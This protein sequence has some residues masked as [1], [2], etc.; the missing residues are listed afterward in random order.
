MR[1]TKGFTLIELLVVI[2]IIALL[3]SILMPSLSKVRALA[4]RMKC[5]SNLSAIAK[6]FGMY[7]EDPKNDGRWP[8]IIG[9][10]WTSPSAPTGTNQEKAPPEPGED[11]DDRAITALPWMLIRERSVTPE[12]FVC[13]GDD[14]VEEYKTDKDFEKLW[15]FGE[16]DPR[17]NLSYVSYAYQAPV[18]VSDDDTGT[19]GNWK[20]G[21]NP[22]VPYPGQVAVMA[23]RDAELV[24]WRSKMPEDERRK[25]LSKNH[26]DTRGGDVINVT[27]LDYH[28]ST[29]ERRADIGYQMDAIYAS[30]GPERG[31]G[32]NDLTK[33]TD[34]MDSFVIGPY[35]K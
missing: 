23:D 1:R 6:G 28:N 11:P 25:G 7:A 5:A 2:G 13:P 29:G 33:H 19:T 4:K 18:W 27:W 8:W 3:V 30:S 17:R 15:D 32:S 12:H 9:E 31:S 22:Q 14:E 34:P 16:M 24:S 10:T 21:C 35:L 26:G 20:N